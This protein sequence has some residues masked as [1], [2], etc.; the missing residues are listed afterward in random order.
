MQCSTIRLMPVGIES[1]SSEGSSFR[2]ALITSMDDSPLN[3]RPAESI[4]YITTPKLKMS[5]R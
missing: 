1:D 3:A 5:E 4:S 2:M